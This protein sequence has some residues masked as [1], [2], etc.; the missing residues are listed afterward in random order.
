MKH[1]IIG[2]FELQYY[3]KTEHRNKQTKTQHKM[4]NESTH[5]LLW[6]QI[7]SSDEAWVHKYFGTLW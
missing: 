4:T 1:H 6:G 2:C 5:K 3:T 7:T